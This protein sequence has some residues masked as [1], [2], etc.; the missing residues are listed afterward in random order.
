MT[1]PEKNLKKRLERLVHF[2]EVFPQKLKLNLTTEEITDQLLYKTGYDLYLNTYTKNE[3]K[4]ALVSTGI[5]DKIRA[6]GFEKLLLEMDTKDPYHQRLCLYFDKVAQSNLLAQIILSTG[7]FIPRKDFL[8]SI[9]IE[10]MDMLIIEWLCLQNPLKKWTPDKPQLPGQDYPGLGVGRITVELIRRVAL[11]LEKD[12]ILN[13]P[14]YYHNAVMYSEIFK[15]YNPEVYGKMLAIK[16]LLKN[17]S[18]SDSAW[19]VYSGCIIDKIKRTK[20]VW[21]SEEMILPLSQTLQ[22]YFSSPEYNRKVQEAISQSKFEVDLKKYE[23]I[24]KTAV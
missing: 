16:E 14:Q 21:K 9:K 7:T 15:F 22:N 2:D 1:K 6:Q 5:W 11:N 23:K 10:K 4:D 17:F 20:F 18:F 8:E 19:I 12:G 24:K 13:Y 3:I